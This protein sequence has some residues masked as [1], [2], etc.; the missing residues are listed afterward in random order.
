MAPFDGRTHPNFGCGQSQ[1][2][3]LWRRLSAWLRRNPLC[4]PAHSSSGDLPWRLGRGALSTSPNHSRNG[5]RRVA[6][7]RSLGNLHA[8]LHVFRLINHKRAFL[9]QPQWFGNRRESS[10]NQ[11]ERERRASNRRHHH[12]QPALWQSLW[13]A[14]QS[15]RPP[16]EPA[17]IPAERFFSLACRASLVAASPTNTCSAYVCTRQRGCSACQR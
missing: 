11:P 6:A 10:I 5:W 17:A 14:G 13:G 4:A 3:S 1:H 16:T 9:A 2:R 15:G 8:G 12:R 7:G